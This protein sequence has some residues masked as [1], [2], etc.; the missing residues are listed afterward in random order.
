M[1]PTTVMLLTVKI[2]VG[3]GSSAEHLLGGAVAADL[4][5]GRAEDQVLADRHAGGRERLAIALQ[6]LAAG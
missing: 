1:A 3:R 5:D 2:A 4:V 6:A